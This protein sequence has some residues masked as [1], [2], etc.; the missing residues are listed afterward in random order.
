MRVYLLD[1]QCYNI[2]EEIVQGFQEFK[3]SKQSNWVTAY[4]D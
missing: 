3:N 1:E 4:G 2:R